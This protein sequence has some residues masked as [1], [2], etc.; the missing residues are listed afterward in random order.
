MFVNNRVAH[1]GLTFLQITTVNSG[2]ENN[3]KKSKSRQI[4]NRELTCE[5]KAGPGA[6][7][8]W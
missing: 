8:G 1:T 6:R 5:V 2:G 7:D 4:R 3:P